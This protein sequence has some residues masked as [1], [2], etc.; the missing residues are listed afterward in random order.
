MAETGIHT[1]PL[2]SEILKNDAHNGELV[3]YHK[4]EHHKD[5]DPSETC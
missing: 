2:W 1:P 3:K 4:I 5:G